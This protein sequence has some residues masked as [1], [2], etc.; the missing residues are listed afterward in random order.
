MRILFFLLQL[1]LILPLFSIQEVIDTGV[2]EDIT[3]FH[4]I[5][6][7]LVENEVIHRDMPKYEEIPLMSIPEDLSIEAHE[8]TI[9]LEK[10]E[11]PELTRQPLQISPLPVITF[12]GLSDGLQVIPP[13]TQGTVGQNHVMTI[14]N[15]RVHIQS[16]IGTSLKL[17][18]D[19][20]FWGISGNI[21]DPKIVYDPFNNRWI[22]VAL[23]NPRT[24]DSRILMAVSRT[25]DP[26][27]LWHIFNIKADASGLTWADFP[28]LGFNN[29][30]IVLQVN[31]FTVSGNSFSRSDIL[32]FNKSIVYAGNATAFKRFS[33]SSIGG[34]QVPAVTYDNTQQN[35]YLV[36]SWNGNS[37][38]RG[39]LR[40]YAI[41]GAI[42][43]ESFVHVAFP[44]SPQPWASSHPIISGGFAPQLTTTQ[45]IMNN[46]ARISNVVYRNNSLWTTHTIFLPA[47]SPTHS[48][49]QW[50]QLTPTGVV[51]Q[52][53]RI[54]DTSATLNS[55]N[56]FAF[57]SIAVNSVNDVL[58]GYSRFNT[59]MFASAAYSFRAAS[60]ILNTMRGSLI[61][62]N[63]LDIYVK[64]F[65]AGRIRWGDYSSTVVDPTNNDFWT[66][67]ESADTRN[68]SGTSRWDTWWAR[69]V[70]P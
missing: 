26:L 42:G 69:V 56:F 41:T 61:Y 33:S 30:W 11:Y 63:G 16:K 24:S 28:S 13:D 53:G 4:V 66:L 12:R 21:F 59:L 3:D 17:V 32:A 19:N 50:W 55:G 70:V 1:T 57:P 37:N 54:E 35:L 6:L 27:G 8:K 18:S 44:A 5:D 9:Y 60:D 45:R 40:L 22:A 36:Q 51:Q 25:N 47:T 58:I 52:R 2:E 39:V 64:D 38:G 10:Q 62:R 15:D 68:S 46:D 7:S 23:T 29:K 48:A 49:V 43:A 20:T 31:M 14:L 65:G 67:Q 34:T